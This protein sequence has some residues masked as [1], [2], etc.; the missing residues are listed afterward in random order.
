MLT[1]DGPRLIELNPRVS[2]VSGMLNYFSEEL[3]G[4]DQASQLIKFMNNHKNSINEKQDIPEKYGIIFY[5]QN[6]GFSYNGI[7]ESLF[8]SLGSY[9]KHL[10]KI[11]TQKEKKYP[12]NLFDTVGFIILSNDSKK[13]VLLDVE[14]LRKWESTGEIYI[15]I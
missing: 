7:N 6:F 10:I 13:D 8:Y 12:E 4:N 11:H 3:T 1:K 5:L 9:K 14:K 15:S 2:G